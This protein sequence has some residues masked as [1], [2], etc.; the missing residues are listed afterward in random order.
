MKPVIKYY[1]LDEDD[2]KFLKKKVID[3]G[4]S[5]RQLAKNMGF[6]PAYLHDVMNGGRHFTPRLKAQF[7]SQGIVFKGE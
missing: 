2:R 6:S 4:I 5:L 7:E 3:M 1:I